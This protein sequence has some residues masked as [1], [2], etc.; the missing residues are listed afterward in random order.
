MDTDTSPRDQMSFLMIDDDTRNALAEFRPTVEKKIDDILESFYQH[1][2]QTPA[3]A[4]LFD[5]H[6]EAHARKHQ[7]RHWLENVFSG[8]FDDQ[9]FQEAVKIGNAHRR[10]GLEPTW[11]IGGYAFVLCR[12][13]GLAVQQYRY[14]ADRLTVALGAI[15]RSFAL[16]L[17]LS[18]ESYFSGFVA[19]AKSRI[20]KSVESI[21]QESSALVTGLTD[22]A[23]QVESCAASLMTAAQQTSHLAEDMNQASADASSNVQTVA[24]ATEELT[25]SIQEIGRQVNQSTQIAQSAVAESQRANTLIQGLVQAA[26]RIGEVVRLINA[27]ASQTNLLALNATI[28]AARAGDAGK[29]FAVVAGEVKSLA[30]QTAR[31]TDEISAQIAAVQ[32]ATREAVTAI[33]AIDNT[34]GSMSEISSAIAAAVE[35]QGA[36]TREIARNVQQAAQGTSQVST[37]IFSVSQANEMTRQAAEKMVAAADMLREQISTLSSQ[38]GSFADRIGNTG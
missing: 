18:L 24:A 2:H 28:E 4:H 29:G 5:E 22:T 34:I 20:R 17:E 9:Y 3:V 11:Y 26:T 10:I 36:A 16:D 6:S 38:Y 31:A 14:K 37:N 13:L 19:D 35:E 15:I 30:N 23:S 1:L 7:R 27:I 32:T 25:A 33:Q 8:R 12:L 21:H